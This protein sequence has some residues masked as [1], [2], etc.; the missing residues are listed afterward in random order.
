[1][2]SRNGR[3]GL[4]F[5][6]PVFVPLTILL[7]GVRFA[8]STA[9][10]YAGL[11]GIDTRGLDAAF[12]VYSDV[13]V[14]TLF[15]FIVA[16]LSERWREL[17][18]DP[19][20]LLF[21]AL[22]VAAFLQWPGTVDPSL[23]FVAGRL[24]PWAD[25]LLGVTVATA[26]AVFTFLRIARL[27]KAS[28]SPR[29]L[30]GALAFGY[31][32]S[33]AFLLR[34]ARLLDVAYLFGLTLPSGLLWLFDFGPSL[35]LA[36]LAVLFWIYLGL[37]HVPDPKD[38]LSSV[39]IPAVLGIVAWTAAVGVLGGFV[40]SNALSWGGSYIVFSPT[41]LSLPIVGFGFGAYLATAWRFRLQLPR[42]EWRLIFGG[43]AIAALA[44]IQTSAGIL[45]SF[46]GVLT[47][48]VCTG[49]GLSKLA[50][51]EG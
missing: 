45:A 14:V 8:A 11:Q 1:M 39:A 43:I 40:L 50:S 41:T 33:V 18:G 21:F 37:L 27:K 26:L 34:S 36:V 16:L 12:E 7:V 25:F 13:L 17:L 15:A 6:G 3:W 32:F 31:A 28:V 51:P 23:R 20:F 4:F 5:D 49:R 44:G 22:A 10:A 48:I 29:A 24:G 46:A 9:T 47:G 2:S 30:G 35:L 38:R 42:S 19:V